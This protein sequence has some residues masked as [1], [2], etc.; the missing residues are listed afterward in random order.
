MMEENPA[1][2]TKHKYGF[3]YFKDDRTLVM[4][5]SLT[6]LFVRIHVNRWM[7]FYDLMF[8]FKNPEASRRY[9]KVGLKLPDFKRL[10]YCGIY[11]YDRGAEV[12]DNL[13]SFDRP[14]GFLHADDLEGYQKDALRSSG[15]SDSD[16]CRVLC[17]SDID[18]WNVC[19][20]Y[21]LPTSFVQ[22]PP[23]KYQR[24]TEDKLCSPLY[25]PEEF[26]SFNW[27]NTNQAFECLHILFHKNLE[28]PD[29]KSIS[30]HKF[31]MKDN[32]ILDAPILID[33]K[34]LMKEYQKLQATNLY[35]L[36]ANTIFETGQTK[37]F[38]YFYFSSKED[39]RS[40]QNVERGDQTFAVLTG[41]LKRG[42]K[43]DQP[44]RV[45]YSANFYFQNPKFF[46]QSEVRSQDS[47]FQEVQH[48][49]FIIDRRILSAKN[50][51]E[52]HSARLAL[53]SI[54]QTLGKKRFFFVYL[55]GKKATRLP[56]QVEPAFHFFPELP[57]NNEDETLYSKFSDDQRP[58]AD[59]SLSAE[60]NRDYRDYDS[61]NSK[62]FKEATVSMSRINS[63]NHKHLCI[64]LTSDPDVFKMYSPDASRQ[65]V[66]IALVKENDTAL[67][68]QFGQFE[69]KLNIKLIL[70][71]LNHNKSLYSDLTAALELQNKTEI[72]FT[73]NSF[74]SLH[75]QLAYPSLNHKVRIST[76][77]N[78]MLRL[79][80]ILE[81]LSIGGNP[82]YPTHVQSKRST[83]EQVDM[84]QEQS[85]DFEEK[86][87][88]LMKR[89]R[90]VVEVKH[91]YC[92]IEPKY[93]N[94]FLPD[95]ASDNRDLSTNENVY[96]CF[97]DF[98]SGVE[99]FNIKRLCETFLGVAASGG[100]MLIN[101]QPNLNPTEKRK[102]ALESNCDFQETNNSAEPASELQPA[103][104][105]V[106]PN[107]QIPNRPDQPRDSLS[108]ENLLYL[109]LYFNSKGQI[110]RKI[111]EASTSFNDRQTLGQGIARAVSVI[112]D[113]VATA[114]SEGKRFVRSNNKE[115]D[116]IRYSVWIS[117]L[118]VKG[119][120]EEVSKFKRIG[121][122]F[123]NKMMGK[124]EHYLECF[125]VILDQAR[126]ADYD[127]NKST[128]TILGLEYMGYDRSPSNLAEYSYGVWFKF[129]LN[130]LIKAPFTVT[131]N[132]FDMI[133]VH[134]SIDQ[135]RHQ[136][137][138]YCLTKIVQPLATVAYLDT[139]DLPLVE[140]PKDS[141]TRQ[142]LRLE[143]V[144]TIDENSVEDFSR[145]TR[146]LMKAVRRE[147]L[148]E[149]DETDYYKSVP[150]AE[151]FRVFDQTIQALWMFG[152]TLPE[153][154]GVIDACI[155]FFFILSHNNKNN[156]AAQNTVKFPK[157][158]LTKV[159][160]IITESEVK[161][162]ESEQHKQKIALIEA[163]VRKFVVIF[164]P[165]FSRPEQTEANQK[166]N[167]S[168]ANQ[169]K[170]AVPK[171]LIDRIVQ[172]PGYI[173]NSET[174]MKNNLDRNIMESYE[175]YWSRLNTDHYRKNLKALLQELIGSRFG[176]ESSIPLPL[177]FQEVIAQMQ[178][179]F[180]F[181]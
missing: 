158:F 166:P 68:T 110:D 55:N 90:L 20:R 170:L 57:P 51:S 174:S 162:A 67:I 41:Y 89:I 98:P 60:A 140:L 71:Y 128:M 44:K 167:P 118:I 6:K 143:K 165:S 32:N 27:K 39:S 94:L 7:V 138:I 100:S 181:M 52:L 31:K 4:E 93:F 99:P 75:F 56:G 177:K 136:N 153:I 96:C 121:S 66:L 115:I 38:Q 91:L 125:K 13:R 123:A 120:D 134:S 12:G 112:D 145:L 88:R 42:S 95:D 34:P 16:S 2:Q 63:R 54:I 80:I 77:K 113:L 148:E 49:F 127:L 85:G 175:T 180:G 3:F 101:S 86:I 126:K 156:L 84:Q 79:P 14:L 130:Q 122:I 83:D 111:F 61:P 9:S 33:S 179:A 72:E 28:Q 160:Q 76:D 26:D 171:I 164:H 144:D 1:S 124:L 150:Y 19:V 135:A 29:P 59:A 74:D 103:T 159:A 70:H 131:K 147:F 8:Y 64:T 169:Q 17:R 5:P 117:E 108:S 35:I 36:D 82:I 157:L 139:N 114:L 97:E 58:E 151:K 154:Y 109:M 37:G 53:T 107:L 23:G 65:S 25:L 78:Q 163:V 172:H 137:P 155:I 47:L 105:R 176:V 62:D 161:S 11:N 40:S 10:T 168:L 15:S 18:K 24:D 50:Q 106:Q 22:K 21:S 104:N 45:R 129:F 141:K 119:I 102:I 48:V 132:L 30:L 43:E 142:Y 173:S 87:K 116:I 178:K 81:S 149:L 73:V 133:H 92:G 152:I 146:N 69:S 46:H